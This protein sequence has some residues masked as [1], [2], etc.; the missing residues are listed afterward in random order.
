VVAEEAGRHGKLV[1]LVLRGG[2][3][4]GLERR[5]GPAA[6]S[7]PPR[8]RPPVFAEA[9]RLRRRAHEAHA[10]ERLDAVRGA[11]AA[12]LLARKAAPRRRVEARDLARPP[13]RRI[14]GARGE[15]EHGGGHTKHWRD[16]TWYGFAMGIHFRTCPLCEATCGL[17]IDI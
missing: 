17:A 4:V 3:L 10:A 9:G 14:A 13:S 1:G 8:R 11:R 6:I 7:R 16:S 15:E 2:L 5:R 12:L